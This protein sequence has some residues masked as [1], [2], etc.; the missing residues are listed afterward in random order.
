MKKTLVVYVFHTYNHRVEC[1]FKNAIFED[2]QI[3]FMVVC[4]DLNFKVYAPPYVKIMNRNNIGYDFG[5]WSDALLTNDLYK[6]YDT[7][8]LAN[9]SIVGPF[10][11]S[12][13]KGKWT[14]IFLEGLTQDVKL[15]GPTINR[16]KSLNV[17]E[18]VHVQSYLFSMNK[19]TLEFLIEKDIFTQKAYTTTMRETIY[20]KE[21]HMSTVILGNKWNIGCLM[22]IY[23]GVNFT[24]F[25]DKN[26]PHLDDIMFV[27]QM[28]QYW[29]PEA[30]VFIKG[31]RVNINLEKWL[32]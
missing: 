20:T 11:P 19:E 29:S 22:P 12:Y 9:S 5:G 7:F 17:P 13:Y 1:F 8:I 4:N 21:I 16:M 14:D 31:N 23:K 25:Y 6:N 26:I 28:L 27:E 32:K 10:L 2:S 15:F 3:D 30:L 18:L 24:D